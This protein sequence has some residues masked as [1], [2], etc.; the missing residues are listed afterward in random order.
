MS[1]MS[2]RNLQTGRHN[3]LIVS[4]GTGRRWPSAA[5][6]T[7]PF[8]LLAVSSADSDARSQRC[9]PSCRDLPTV[10]QPPPNFN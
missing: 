7:K 1:H 4:L 2:W 3:A 6:L 5:A 8:N 10:G 9:Q